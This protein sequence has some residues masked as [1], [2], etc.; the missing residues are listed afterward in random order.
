MSDLRRTRRPRAGLLATTLAAGLAAGSVALGA[1]V[2]P[3]QAAGSPSGVASSAVDSARAVPTGTCPASLAEHVQQVPDIVVGTVA[4]ISEE[5]AEADVREIV[6]TDPEVLAGDAQPTE[7]VVVKTLGVPDGTI[8]K[9]AVGA[10]YVVFL[11]PSNDEAGAAYGARLCDF[12]PGAQA[13]KVEEAVAQAESAPEQQPDAA[14]VSWS[15][16]SSEDGMEYGEAV[17]P[18]VLIGAI[19]AF[20]LAGTVLLSAVVGRRH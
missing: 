3:A 8:P 19:G 11:S 18:G 16:I 15:Q 2:A 20:G 17:L 10:P 14:A 1:G 9:P 7:D 5:S 13:A 12:L 6:L 4:G